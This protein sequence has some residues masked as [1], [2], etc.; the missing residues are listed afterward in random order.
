MTKIIINLEALHH[1][2][3]VIGRWMNSNKIQWSVVTKV[4][5]GHVETLTALQ[6]LGV[7]SMCD[8]RIPNLKAIQRM[9]PDFETWYLRPPDV[10]IIQ[11]VI[12]LSDVSLN[13]EVKV[14]KLLN[15][16]AKVQRK[17]HRII[18]MVELGDLREGVLPGNLVHFYAQVFN[19]SN[20]EVLGIGANLGCLAGVLPN[21]DQFMQLILYKELLELKF[22]LKLPLIS[23]G[24]SVVLP[25]LLDKRLPKEINHFR[26]GESVFL[27]T[28]LIAGGMLSELS[29]DVVVLEAEIVEIKEKNLVPLSETANVTPFERLSEKEYTPGQ[30]GFR[31][32]VT[33]GQLDTEI[34]GLTPV[35]ERYEIAGASS[36]IT[37]VNLDDNPNNLKVGDRLK[38][39]MNY[40]ALLGSMSGKYIDKEIRPS[41]KEFDASFA[42]VNDTEVV[43]VLENF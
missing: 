7:R 32:L 15:E 11:N 4:L 13:S 30:R 38:F 36:D 10:S 37:V 14:I 22:G 29:G 8:S 17:V 28:D 16:E 42:N 24:S 26:I 39:R 18:I 31:A 5:C 41:L 3:S 34:T 35:D 27:G 12:E 1:N 43:P 20:I 21:I 23:A 9:V 2:V 19:L 40:S 25:L 33:V 6:L